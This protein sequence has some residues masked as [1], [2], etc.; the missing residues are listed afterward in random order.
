MNYMTVEEFA[1][2]IRMCRH[3]VRNAIRKGKIY[4]IR[5]S[6]GKR[7]PY[8]IPRTELERLLAARMHEWDNAKII[9]ERKGA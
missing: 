5:P 2:E 7:S 4:A 1:K 6:I 3:S 8:R 9:E